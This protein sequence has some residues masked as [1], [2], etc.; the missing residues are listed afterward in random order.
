MP[1]PNADFA[2]QNDPGNQPRPAEA[3]SALDELQE[4]LLAGER[5]NAA[6]LDQRLT[7]LEDRLADR[8]AVADIVAPALADAVRQKISQERDDLVE[9]LYPIIGPLVTRSV[10]EAI[11]DLVRIIDAR[12][13]QPLTPRSLGRRMRAAM[14]G[15][16]ASELTLREALPFELTELFLIHRESGLLLCHLSGAGGEPSNSD[17]ISGL[18][19]AIRDFA[20]DAFGR[21]QEGQLDEIQ[22]G[23]R[24]ILIEAAR[25]V[26]LAA[27]VD[28]V[29]PPGFRAGM[30]KLVVELDTA[31]QGELRNYQGQAGI[32]EPVR[33]QLEQF[34]ASPLPPDESIRSDLSKGQKRMLLAV[35]GLS[36]A[37]VISICLAGAWLVQ[38]T[39]M[40]RQLTTPVLIVV[41][42]TPTDTVPVTAT[43]TQTALPSPTPTESAEPSPSATRT[44]TSSPTAT[45][46]ATATRQTTA[47]PTGTAT[48]AATTGRTSAVTSTATIT[49]SPTGTPAQALQAVIPDV[50]VN[51]RAGPSLEFPVLAIVEPGQTFQIVGQSPD[52]AW[53][54]ICCL[55][56][57]QAG[58]IFAELI[59]QVIQ[60]S[61]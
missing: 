31:L 23:E 48:P 11:R 3:T 24:S 37:C 22:Y 38:T 61:E 19:T 29:E 17:L 9:A 25:F 52:R 50:R 15:V 46:A 39:Q 42:A 44:A 27:V 1:T 56:D 32:A 13:R 18:L 14:S 8:D 12:I 41:T 47:T 16:T 10:S 26:Y 57:G 6:S 45:V 59:L 30:R 60:P 53:L 33:P 49:R 4:I 43:P 34:L 20:E 36:L 54:R 28:G 40:L 5:N 35:L 7:G 58:W 51:V 21:R 55:P 2:Q